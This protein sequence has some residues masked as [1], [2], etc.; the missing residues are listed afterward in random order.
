[1]Y[2]F[3]FM[4]VSCKFSYKS[5]YIL[6]EFCVASLSNEVVI[7]EY[8]HY[9]RTIQIIFSFFALLSPQSSGKWLLLMARFS[10]DKDL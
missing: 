4:K 3:I 5:K 8:M 10:G 1:M 9:A 6:S 2:V 7:L